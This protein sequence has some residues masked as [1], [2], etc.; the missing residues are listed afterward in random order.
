MSVRP[1]QL[2]RCF[3]FLMSAR[4]GC[5]RYLNTLSNEISWD[6]MSSKI[7]SL[8]HSVFAESLNLSQVKDLGTQIHTIQYYVAEIS[9]VLKHWWGSYAYLL[10]C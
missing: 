10:L 9:T 5:T 8:M 7:D 3:V 6:H 1:S 4:S 2:Q